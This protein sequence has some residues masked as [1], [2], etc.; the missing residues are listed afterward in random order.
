MRQMMTLKIAKIQLWEFIELSFASNHGINSSPWG[1]GSPC[2]LMCGAVKD[3]LTHPCVPEFSKH[4]ETV[5]L[6]RWK[7][8]TI[9]SDGFVS[10]ISFLFL[11]LKL[12]EHKYFTNLLFLLFPTSHHD[13]LT[14]PSPSAPGC[15]RRPSSCCLSSRLVPGSF[16]ITIQ[17]AYLDCAWVDFET[18]SPK[19]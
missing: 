17:N 14:T 15:K 3:G 19:R 8:M 11:S 9:S 13:L 1:T 6:D 5:D 18:S 4:L 2:S 16:Q 12:T 7:L 10:F